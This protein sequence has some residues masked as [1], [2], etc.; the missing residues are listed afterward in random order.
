MMIGYVTSY[1]S[2][3]V[4]RPICNALS[5]FLVLRVFFRVT[6][7]FFV[8]ILLKIVQL[9]SSAVANYIT[10]LFKLALKPL[11]IVSLYYKAVPCFIILV[12]ILYEEV[13]K[14]ITVTYFVLIM[15]KCIFGCFFF[16]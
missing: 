5:L 1:L 11:F 7:N 16:S 10:L 2:K 4:F 9:R 15:T 6:V 14:V 13:A 3:E 12:I 8:I